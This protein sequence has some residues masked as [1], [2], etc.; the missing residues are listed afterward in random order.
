MTSLDSI[1]RVW[2][3][4]NLKK[5]DLVLCSGTRFSLI[6]DMKSK[7]KELIAQVTDLLRKDLIQ[8]YQNNFIVTMN[9]CINDAVLEDE[10]VRKKLL[11]C[12]QK[13][14]DDG[15]LGMIKSYLERPFGDTYKN[16]LVSNHL[17]F[18]KN[19]D[20]EDLLK[21]K[22]AYCCLSYNQKTSKKPKF[23]Q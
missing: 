17:A 1:V 5:E 6:K 12:I 22:N 3:K 10:A 18:L 7:S 2:N 13:K 15:Y 19:A 8:D 20:N 9:K 23:C 21:F 14:H 16:D 11:S 4:K